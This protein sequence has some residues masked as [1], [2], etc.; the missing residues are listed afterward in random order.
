MMEEPEYLLDA[1]AVLAL[2]QNEPGA[3][4]VAR[5]LATAAISAVN[6][7]EVITILVRRSGDPDAAVRMILLLNLQVLPWGESSAHHSRLFAYLADAALSL[8]DRACIT[9][10]MSFA[11]TR[12]ATTDRA[13]KKVRNIA[14][15]VILIR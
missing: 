10:G 8:G 15:R 3:D 1:S 5:M 13:W 11:K 6:L 4:Q 9:E 14:S 12:I 7:A 2:I